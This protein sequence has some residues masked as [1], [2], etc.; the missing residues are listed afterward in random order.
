VLILQDLQL[1]PEAEDEDLDS[2]F[3]SDSETEVE[4]C[5][6]EDVSVDLTEAIQKILGDIVNMKDIDDLNG[7]GQGQAGCP[8]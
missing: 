5:N 7:D 3:I 1:F 6:S 4:S 8:K 2:D